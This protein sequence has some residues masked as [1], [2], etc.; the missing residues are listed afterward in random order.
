[1]LS[2]IRRFGILAT[3]PLLAACGGSAT[4][5]PTVY[6][7][8]AGTDASNSVIGGNGI[9]NSQLV[10]LSGDY[11]HDSGALTVTDGT[12]TLTDSDGFD[13][14]DV[15]KDGVS[16][17]RANTSSFAGTYEFAR[18]F[19]QSNAGGADVFGVL[20]LETAASDMPQSITATYVGE[21]TGVIDTGSQGFTL[22]DGTSHIVANFD[23]GT[24][25]V[26]MSDFNIVDVFTE[27]S[28]TGPIDEISITGM[29]ISGNTFR[30]G[31]ITT[32]LNGATVDLIGN[33]AQRNA[34][35]S[36]LGI[37][38]DGTRPDEVGG[39]VLLQGDSGLVNGLFVANAQ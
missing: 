13:A 7:A 10:T 6:Q 34:A 8:F 14:D 21:A 3:L 29:L 38:S 20:G 35:G 36:F 26:T 5:T 33:N 1:M 31:T 16:T 32:R 30:N 37:T 39:A 24:V 22:S 27:A 25:N 23:I 2:L 17:L 15:A 11:Q 19:V 9:K 4:T 28:V 18:P 12:Y